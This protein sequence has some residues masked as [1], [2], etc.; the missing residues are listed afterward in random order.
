MNTERINDFSQIIMK[1]ESN[2]YSS[3][4]KHNTVHI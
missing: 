4:F 2:D 1:T 3:N